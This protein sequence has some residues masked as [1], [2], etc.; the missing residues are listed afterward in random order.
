MNNSSKST[1]ILTQERI[2]DLCEELTQLALVIAENRELG[3]P[4]SEEL[5]QRL[6][7]LRSKLVN[8][9]QDLAGQEYEREELKIE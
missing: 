7:N 3:T 5:N 1:P 6:P 2:A 4:I 9:E 8:L